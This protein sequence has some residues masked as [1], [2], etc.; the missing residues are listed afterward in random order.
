[1]EVAPQ[2]K[3]HTLLTLLPLFPLFTPLALFTLHKLLTLLP[4]LVNTTDTVTLHILLTLLRDATPDQFCSFLPRVFQC[5]KAITN[6]GFCSNRIL[7]YFPLSVHASVTGVTS[8]FS[9]IYKGINAKLIIR[10]PSTPIYSESKS[11]WLSF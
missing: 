2:P 9:H 3:L 7:H 5:Q 4:L 11:S 8:H 6:C 1:M 10:D